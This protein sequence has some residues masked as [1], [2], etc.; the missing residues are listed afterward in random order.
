MVD[1]K[2]WLSKSYEYY[3]NARFAPAELYEI[4]CQWQKLPRVLD[5]ES[6]KSEKYE[7]SEILLS[8]SFVSE[9]NKGRTKWSRSRTIH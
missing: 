9:D 2:D 7:K 1:E 3:A 5:T 6:W 4:P 8:S